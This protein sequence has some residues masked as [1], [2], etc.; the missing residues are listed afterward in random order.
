MIYFDDLNPVKNFAYVPD[1]DYFPK[2]KLE[3]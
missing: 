1:E 2:G 3:E